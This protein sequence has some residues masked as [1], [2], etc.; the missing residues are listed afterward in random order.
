M[1]SLGPSLPFPANYEPPKLFWR[2]LPPRDLYEL[3][4]YRG[5]LWIIN[6][7]EKP[8]ALPWIEEHCPKT[9]IYEF[10]HLEYYVFFRTKKQLIHF[11]LVWG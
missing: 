1:V 7:S 6:F 8:D 9:L 5:G 11:K 4:V 3:L 2:K 10:D